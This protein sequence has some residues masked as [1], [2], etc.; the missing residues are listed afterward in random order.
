M[1]AFGTADITTGEQH[2]RM[3]SG[4]TPDTG[5]PVGVRDP[6]RPDAPPLTAPDPGD[7]PVRIQDDVQPFRAA[8]HGDPAAR[9]IHP[10]GGGQGTGVNSANRLPDQFLVARGVTAVFRGPDGYR[11]GMPAVTSALW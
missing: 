1:A 9:G 3:P 10:Q 2:V 7:T 4:G 11:L 6:S 8:V 5:Q